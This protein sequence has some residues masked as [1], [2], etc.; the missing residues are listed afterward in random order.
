MN[1][2]RSIIL[3][4]L[5]SAVIGIITGCFT[6]SN[7]TSDSNITGITSYENNLIIFIVVLS[8]V[9]L[10]I[11]VL[12]I[13]IAQKRKLIARN[14]QSALYI[15]T[16]ILNKSDVMIY[17]TDTNTDEILFINDMMKQHF[18]LDNSV[19]GKPCYRVLQEG[20]TTRCDFCPCY[21]LDKAPDNVIVWEE[22]NSKTN[23]FYRKSD[24]YTDWPDGKKVHIQH[25]IDI[26]DIKQAQ[27]DLEHRDDLLHAV[28]S[29]AAVL[30]TMEDDETYQTSF[31][32][33]MKIIG[34]G[35]GA[36]CVEVWQNEMIDGE[37]HAVIKYYWFSDKAQ[38]PKPVAAFHSFPYSSTPDWENRLSRGECIKGSLLTLSPE[39]RAFVDPFGIK[40]LL[41]IPVFMENRL[42]GM[43]CID[44]YSKY[45]DFSEDE[46]NILRSVAYM[47]ASTIKRQVLA[48][49]IREANNRTKIL[50]DKTPLC[51]QLWDSNFNKI[52]CNQEAI[53]LF[54]FKDKQE[55]LERYLELYPEYQSDGMRTGE[56]ALIS[57]KKAFEEGSYT[58]DWIYKLLDGTL[59]PAEV[60][61]VRVEYEDGYAVA[62]YTRDLREHK[63]MMEDIYY[64][65]SLLNAVNRA[66]AFLLN[67][68]IETF[69]N[70]LYRSMGIIAKAVKAD[71]LYICKNHV[72]NGQVCH[73][74]LYEWSEGAQPLQNTELVVDLPYSNIS[75]RWEEFLSQ[76]NC[77]NGIVRD[78]LPQE[79]AFLSPQSILSILLVPVFIKERFWGIVG[80][81]DCHSERVFS[82][83][84]VSILQSGGLLFTNALLRNDM[85]QN[86]RDTSARL[87]SALEQAEAASKAKGDF[88][89]AMSH[90]MRTPMNAII[91]MTTIGKK[92]NDI[93]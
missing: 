53:R 38:H 65:D 32:E 56:K 34:N 47:M 45:R 12:M 44:D 85:I 46:V 60:T 27:K 93:E 20:Q 52:D 67:S 92:A 78:M 33:G 4:V 18:K 83:E 13:N 81:D 41:T 71:R 48:S 75:P 36:D 23:R 24:Q 59:M 89:S 17:V 2:K 9:L 74:Q 87:E 61:L 82:E 28:N 16:S 25:C 1:S 55:Y 91:G 64:R 26:T 90:E 68:D 15:M 35:V 40:S 22:Y 73:T 72:S 8:L 21:Q 31:M 58:S 57:V 43:C 14:L 19:I 76:G 80:F 39:D 11:T 79:Q 30:L 3:M 42:W 63:K 7:Q 77:V 86:I 88:L 37:L 51:C 54:G 29:A 6:D 5:I 84:E 10:V 50:L 66:A 70:D 69:K 62:G 49:A